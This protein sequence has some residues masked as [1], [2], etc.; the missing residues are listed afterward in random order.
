MDLYRQEELIEL[1]KQKKKYLIFLISFQ[2]LAWLSFVL[3]LVLSNYHNQVIYKIIFSILFTLLFIASALMLSKFWYF[4]KI[5]HEY[6]ILYKR[7]VK[8]TYKAI[9]NEIKDNVITL[10]DG[11]RVREVLCLVKDE[12]RR[13]LLSEIFEPNLPLNKE[14]ILIIKFDYIVGYKDAN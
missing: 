12:N 9:I 1:T 11:S 2:I 14:I 10:P 4:K 6:E 8:N 5:A 7:S 13:F 3:A